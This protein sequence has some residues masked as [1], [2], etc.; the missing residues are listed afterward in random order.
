M[1]EKKQEPTKLSRHPL[2]AIVV[3]FL[4]TGIAGTWL[5][6]FYSERQIERDRFEQ[7]TEARRAALQEF[8]TL[9]YHR[10]TRAQMLAS[11]LRRSAPLEE[12]KE[13]KRLYDDAFV[14]WGSTLQANLFLIRSVMESEGYSDFERH[15]EFRLVPI[16]REVDACLTRAFDERLRGHGTKAILQDCDITNS[17][18]LALDCSYAITDGL[19]QLAAPIEPLSLP[20]AE[21]RR[22]SANREIKKKCGGT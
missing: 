20:E 16:L 15:V 3:G 10:L 14:D 8:A 13:R 21:R 7:I 5:S 2:V 1:V 19:F 22:S 4:L 9:I 18:Q 17:L 11:S 6:N 12:L